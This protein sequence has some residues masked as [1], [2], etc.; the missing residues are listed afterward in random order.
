[1]GGETFPTE[2]HLLI[3]WA[4]PETTLDIGDLRRQ[5]PNLKITYKQVTTTFNRDA[6]TIARLSEGGKTWCTGE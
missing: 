2:G 5:F 3:A 4:F 1:M 6:E